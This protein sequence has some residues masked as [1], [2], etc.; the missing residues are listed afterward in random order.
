MKLWDRMKHAYQLFTS[1]LSLPDIMRGLK[2]DASSTYQ[3][4][5]RE[6][7]PETRQTAK[8]PKFFKLLK[9]LFMAFIKK[10]TP[11]RRIAY[12]VVLVFFFSGLND[13]NG[14][15]KVLLS[16]ILMNLLLAA[17]LADKLT[18]KDELDIARNIQTDMLPKQPP[19]DERFEIAFQY[20]SA[21]TVGGDFYD[22]LTSPKS[23]GFVSMV[24][25]ISG[26]GMEAALHMV[27][28]HALIHSNPYPSDLR[29]MLLHLNKKLQALFPPNQFLT[30]GFL[31]TDEKGN[32]EFYRAG[33]LPLYH[34]TKKGTRCRAVSPDGIGLGLT[35][36]NQ[37]DKHLEKAEIKVVSGDVLC[38][39]TD[40]VIETENPAGVEFGETLLMELLNRCKT[41]SADGIVHF[42]LSEITQYRD[43][44]SKKDDIT[45]LVI[46]VK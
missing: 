5:S 37:L 21:N 40:G 18:A 45:L 14:Q 4:Y 27:Q 30:A 34:C 35:D 16:F 7:D 3:F 17:E 41:K 8:K 11:V 12:I 22:F 6:A 25:D 2:S 29:V 38:L 46:K 13:D 43:K 19:A 28:V 31:K 23:G 32:F 1:D 36:K 44:A 26:K 15:G 10:M 20:E 24:G 42:L 33:H 39:C 9:N